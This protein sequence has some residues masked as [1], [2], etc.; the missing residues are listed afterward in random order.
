[1][2]KNGWRSGTAMTNSAMHNGRVAGDGICS[3]DYS[4]NSG[5]QPGPNKG[6]YGPVRFPHDCDKAE[7]LNGPC[8]IVQK[9]RKK[10]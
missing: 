4:E 1:M 6:A 3:G 2:R 5:Y 7:S 9:G 8:I 10:E